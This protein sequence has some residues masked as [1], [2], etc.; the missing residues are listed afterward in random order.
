MRRLCALAL[1]VLCATGDQAEA[2]QGIV[3]SLMPLHLLEIQSSEP[4]PAVGLGTRIADVRASSQGFDFHVKGLSLLER[5]GRYHV[6]FDRLTVR[7]T[8]GRGRALQTSGQVVLAQLPGVIR[9]PSL[10]CRYADLLVSADLGETILDWSGQSDFDR[11]SRLQQVRL[12][13]LVVRQ[14]LASRPCSFDG[15]LSA[16][17]LLTQLSTGHRHSASAV[18]ASGS[19]PLSL[20]AAALGGSSRINIDLSNFASTPR[21]EVPL[22]GIEKAGFRVEMLSQ[23]M[24]PFVYLISNYLQSDQPVNGGQIRGEMWNAFVASQM[25]V[26]ASL[27]GLRLFLPGILPPSLVANFSRAGLTYAMARMNVELVQSQSKMDVLLDL[28]INGLFHGE[29]VAN[30]TTKAVSIG[31]LADLRDAK[32]LFNS[33]DVYGVN[34]IDIN[35]QDQGLDAVMARVFGLPLGRLIE[36]ATGFASAQAPGAG[37]LS[38]LSYAFRAAAA[39]QP[40]KMTFTTALEGGLP[41]TA[42]PRLIMLAAQENAFDLKTV[43]MSD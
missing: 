43:V 39:G 10:L 3:L 32:L 15:T 25:K 22:I 41:I 2:D 1:L 19:L 33:V 42:P 29:I 13:S 20:E 21:T 7:E 38:N 40:L 36:K 28:F 5:D 8:G 17:G 27:D 14:E 18:Q 4:V 23:R 12:E 9:D 30:G 24:V 35:Y 26:G 6:A 16:S 37:F 31:E 34:M 11:A